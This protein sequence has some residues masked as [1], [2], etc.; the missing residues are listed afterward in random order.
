MSVQQEP[1]RMNQSTA[2]EKKEPVET[3]EEPPKLEFARSGESLEAFGAAL[4]GAVLG[5][6]AT[7]L[8]LAIINNGTLR[9]T[10]AG[11]E[12]LQASVTR[13]DENLGAVSHNID[14]VAQRMTALESEG[15][16]ISQIQGSIA[17]L[18]EQIAAQSASLAELDVTRRNFDTFTMALAQVLSEMNSDESAAAAEPVA[19]EAVEAEAV[20]AEATTEEAP[21]AETE[22]AA[23]AEAA[24][25]LAMPMISADAALAGNAIAA[26]LFVD[27][28]ADGMLNAEEAALVGASFTLTPAEGEAVSAQTTDT[29]AVFAELAAGEY[30]VT[31]TD[32]LGFE[33]ASDT[34]AIVTVA[35]EAAEGQAVYFPVVAGE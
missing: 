15:G 32:A 2:S 6:L 13:I 7:L 4:G 9:F 33:L 25:A 28:N 26:Y 35:E 29:G 5:V 11:G 14:V 20:T 10:G 22:A 1:I 34:V 17:T 27:N 3:H 21:A 16:A 8:I 30:I 18:D 23:E 31:V 12:S 19:A 24:P